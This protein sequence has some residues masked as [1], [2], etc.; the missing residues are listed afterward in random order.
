MRIELR[1]PELLQCAPPTPHHAPGLQRLLGHASLPPAGFPKAGL[2]PS[3]GYS[4]T[5]V[6]VRIGT[7]ISGGCNIHKKRDSVTPVSSCGRRLAP[8]QEPAAGHVTY[9]VPSSRGTCQQAVA[10]SV[11]YPQ[12]IIEHY[13][14]L[15]VTTTCAGHAAAPASRTT[16]LGQAGMLQARPD[17]TAPARR[18][19]AVGDYG[20]PP[21]PL[22]KPTAFV[23]E[24]VRAECA[25]IMLHTS[26]K[27][28]YDSLKYMQ[29]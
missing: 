22:D 19:P 20:A 2:G 16:C 11:A 14:C 13:D 12:R 6:R 3:R 18:A 17:H 25:Q 5:G 26:T 10:E 9:P 29:Q 8:D 7:G 1:K 24:P 28:T 15:R 4:G 23:P 27:S 21:S